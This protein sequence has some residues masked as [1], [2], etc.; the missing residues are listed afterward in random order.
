[1]GEE[2][3]IKANLTGLMNI[4]LQLAGALEHLI[5]MDN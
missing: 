3:A 5:F 4:F 1:M 2:E